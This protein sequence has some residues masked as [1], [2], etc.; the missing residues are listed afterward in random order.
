L[1]PELQADSHSG[2]VAESF[3]D[4]FV[5][6]LTLPQN[7]LLKQY[8]ALLETEVSLWCLRTMRGGNCEVAYEVNEQWK[9]RRKKV[10]HDYDDP[11]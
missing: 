10:A 8:A 7:A 9:H 1:I 5:K 3:G 11:S 4:D 6:I 2:R